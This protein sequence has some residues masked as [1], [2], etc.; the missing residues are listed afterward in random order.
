MSYHDT[1]FS[2]FQH[3]KIVN[4]KKIKDKKILISINPEDQKNIYAYFKLNNDQYLYS[5]KLDAFYNKIQPNIAT[6]SNS[7]FDLIQLLKSDLEHLNNSNLFD[8]IK[9]QKISNLSKKY[10]DKKFKKVYLDNDFI[11]LQPRKH[12]TKK[13]YLPKKTLKKAQPKKQPPKKQPPKKQPP[14]KLS[15]KKQPPK[16]LPP[17]KLSKKKS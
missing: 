4:G 6:Q 14:K 1:N 5:D 17:K 9:F 11:V 13:I 15:P 12:F 2:S 16:K 10:T 8:K 3:T 7:E